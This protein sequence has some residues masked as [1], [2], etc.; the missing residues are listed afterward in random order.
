MVVGHRLDWCI[1]RNCNRSCVV[2]DALNIRRP[3]GDTENRKTGGEQPVIMS[4]KTLLVVPIN[5]I[6]TVHRGKSDGK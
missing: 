1:S 2:F 4:E 3:N 5:S 6:I